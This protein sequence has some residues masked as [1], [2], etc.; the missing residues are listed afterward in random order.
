MSIIH[1]RNDTGRRCGSFV[2]YEYGADLFGFFYLDVVQ[3]RKHRV[4]RVR[5]LLFDNPRDFI[6]VLD[7]DLD[8]RD[9]LNYVAIAA[10]GKS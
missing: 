5:Q 7:R 4:R 8:R 1:M 2:R 6:C 10:A 3:G 9:N